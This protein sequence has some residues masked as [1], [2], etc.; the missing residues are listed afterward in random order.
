[1][2]N[3]TGAWKAL[4]GHKID[5]W[6]LGYQLVVVWVW[7]IAGSPRTGGAAATVARRVGTKEMDAAVEILKISISLNSWSL[8]IRFVLLYPQ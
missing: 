5:G 4:V 8:E 6:L 2:S 1:V 3:K 7:C